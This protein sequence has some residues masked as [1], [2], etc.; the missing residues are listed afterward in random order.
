MLILDVGNSS[1]KAT[2]GEREILTPS[3]VGEAQP[4]WTDQ[5]LWQVFTLFKWEEM[6]VYCS[7]SK[8][9][10]VVIFSLN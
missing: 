10:Y 1:I 3:V 4:A 8:P 2:D 6:K 9:I 7:T 5:Q